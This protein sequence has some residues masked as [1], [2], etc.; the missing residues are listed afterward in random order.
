MSTEE[1]KS[2]G[3]GMVENAKA[4]VMAAKDKVVGAETK[5]AGPGMM[6]NAKTSVMAA[7]DKVV[8]AE[9][10]PAG[11]GMMENAKTSVIN[12]KD[13]VFE[14]AGVAMGNAQQCGKDGA[15]TVGK[16]TNQAGDYFNKQTAPAAAAPVE[17]KKVEK[18]EEAATEG[19]G[20]VGD[21]V[22]KAKGLFKILRIN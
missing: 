20:G 13:K 11:P 17:E 22:N 4:S 6:E 2:A 5:P 16:Y 1:T 18:K 19:G 12:A 14:A 9:T 15:A 21:Y 8:G 10:K 7:K 3:P